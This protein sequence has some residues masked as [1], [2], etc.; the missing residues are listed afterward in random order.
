MKQLLFNKITKATNEAS[1]QA[2]QQKVSP[3]VYQLLAC[4]CAG[5]R[6][7]MRTRGAELLKPQPHLFSHDC[8]IEQKPL[9]RELFWGAQSSQQPVELNNRAVW[10]AGRASRILISMAWNRPATWTQ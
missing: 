10:Q 5:A 2:H 4:C 7:R 6:M 9:L 8:P 3:L 1:A